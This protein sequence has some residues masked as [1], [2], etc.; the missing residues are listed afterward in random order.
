MNVPGTPERPL[1]VAIIGSGPSGFYAAEQLLKQEDLS[2]EVDMFERL[3]TPYGLVRGGVAPDHPKIKSVTKVFDRIAAKP[4]FSYYGHVE[5]G[6]D[7][8]RDDLA[9]HY[10]ALIYATGTQ[11]NRK[12]GIPGEHL[13]GCYGATEFVAWYNGHPDYCDLEF[14]F[15]RGCAMVVG[16]GNVAMDVARMLARTTDELRQTDVADYAL[17]ELATSNIET[18]HI[19]GRRGPVQSKFTPH[20]LKEI[21]E[22]DNVDVIVI[23]EELELDPASR[24]YIE[25]GKHKTA[26]EN[27]EL[28]TRYANTPPA[29]KPK[30]VAF[31]FLISPVEIIGTD[32]VEAIKIAKNELY[33]DEQGRLRSRHTGEY[34]TIPICAIFSSVGYQGVPLPGVPFDEARGT[35]PNVKGRVLTQPDGD[36]QSIGDYVAGWIKRGPSGVIGTN[37]PDSTETVKSLLEDARQGKLL[38]P[39]KPDRAAVESLLKERGIRYISY[40]EWQILDRLEIERGKAE[41]RPRRKFSD[42]DEMLKALDQHT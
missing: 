6:S 23:P 32:T 11:T 30:R 2:V 41:G 36:E 42:V 12:L 25:S 39:S 4:G 10:H 15:L 5:F 24:V 13:S 16:L 31:R 9:D 34:E 40:E 17:K 33:Q 7:V 26:A 38:T 19:V 14:D 35:I 1:R 8:T 22:L 20:E 21:G 27:F 29:G 37:K 28:L 3:P 18:I